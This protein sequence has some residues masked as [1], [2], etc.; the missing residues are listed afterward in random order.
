MSGD[1]DGTGRVLFD[2]HTTHRA[3]TTEFDRPKSGDVE[4][5]K[6]TSPDGSV[7]FAATGRQILLR[8]HGRRLL[9]G[10]RTACGGSARIA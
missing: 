5:T 4:A 10:D 1:S 2:R 8:A 9:G 7:L 3:G 6:A